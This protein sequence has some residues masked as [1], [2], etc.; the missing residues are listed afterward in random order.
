MKSDQVASWARTAQLRHSEGRPAVQHNSG[1]SKNGPL[2]VGTFALL[3][4]PPFHHTTACP[5]RPSGE[6]AD[7]AIKRSKTRVS[8][9]TG[10]RTPRLS[11]NERSVGLGFSTIGGE[12]PQKIWVVG[13]EASRS[14][15]LA[16]HDIGFQ[17]STIHTYTLQDLLYFN[18]EPYAQES[19]R[20]NQVITHA[21]HLDGI[22]V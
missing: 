14:K 22:P 5:T 20:Q 17:L 11:R 21:T 10:G 6:G 13:C 1:A 3:A 15:K 4:Q 19:E 8:R 12:S 7:A 9:A 2:Y 18:D 16:T